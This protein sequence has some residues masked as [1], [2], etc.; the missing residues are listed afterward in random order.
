MKILE[1]IKIIYQHFKGLT[2]I[3]ISTAITNFIGA[4]FWL[5]M[6][7]LLGTE[8]Y[9]QVSYL[10]AIG[11]ISSRISLVGSTNTLMVYGSKGLKIQPPIFLISVI[12]SIIISIIIYFAFLNNIGV[13]LYIIGYV[14]FTLV[15]SDLLGRKVYKE[16]AKYIVSQKILLVVL[17]VVLFYI[18]GMDGVILGIAISFFPYVIKIIKELKKEKID[19]MIIKS[20]KEFIF[21]NY[22]MDLIGAFNGNIDK[23]IIAPL[24][25]FVLLGNYQLAAQF[26]QIL[27]IL[28]AMVFQYTLPQDASGN[29]NRGL[30][31]GIIIISIVL[32]ILG[33]I[34]FPII[35][36]IFFPEF[37]ESIQ[38]IQIM[39]I[40][41]IPATI[42]TTY[43][44]KFLGNGNSRIVLIGSLIFL[45]AFLSSIIILG[46][47]YGING[48]ASAMVIG[49]SIQTMFLIVIS[50]YKK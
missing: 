43:N 39:T 36:P 13:S 8:L 45:G 1:K 21:N 37:I 2:V 48:V 11:I 27:I 4:L 41:I 38:V 10:L 28:P 35:S 34:L 31:K 44:S 25:G 46:N 15:S 49:T 5:S 6:A 50:K 17:A 3:S 7:P 32:A 40:A 20:K 42:I 22:I 24:L 26:F 23:L 19:F 9:G 47:L 16:F 30:K 18:L 33:I 12:T 14:I 29:T